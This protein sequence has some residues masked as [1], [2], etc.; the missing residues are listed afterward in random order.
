M[1]TFVLGQDIKQLAFILTLILKNS[2][3][4]GIPPK[5]VDI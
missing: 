2:N 5:N 1:S 4:K 3:L